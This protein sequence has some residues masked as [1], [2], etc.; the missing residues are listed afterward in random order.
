[1]MSTR[2][3]IWHGD[4]YLSGNIE[5]TNKRARI[6]MPKHLWDLG[7]PSVHAPFI[8]DAKTM[9]LPAQKIFSATVRKPTSWISRFAA[10]STAC[11]FLGRLSGMQRYSGRTYK[12]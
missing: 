7:C 3:A 11:A 1:M 6:N 8:D 2:A 4:R 9:R 12:A 5:R 10:M